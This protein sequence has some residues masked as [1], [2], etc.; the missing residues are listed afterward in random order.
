M[1]ALT[2]H[3][4]KVEAKVTADAGVSHGIQQYSEDVGEAGRYIVPAAA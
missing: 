1:Q 3:K 4:A 2:S